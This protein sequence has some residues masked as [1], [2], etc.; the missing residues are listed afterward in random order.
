MTPVASPGPMIARYGDGPQA[1]LYA[2]AAGQVGEVE[3]VEFLF[4]FARLLKPLY[5]LELGT[6]SGTTTR[7]IGEALLANGRGRL[8][9]IDSDERAT[10]KGRIACAG[11]PVELVTSMSQ[12]FVPSDGKKLHGIDLLFVDSGEAYE[13]YGDVLRFR[14]IT[15]GPIII[16]DTGLYPELWNRLNGTPGLDAIPIP[17]PLGLTIARWRPM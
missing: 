17:S 6:G 16:H 14:P 9:S 15:N 13:R 2:A 12:E 3:M 7:A 10:A 5:A 11:L 4:A 1:E 8:D